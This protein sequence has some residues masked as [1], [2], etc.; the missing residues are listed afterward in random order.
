VI[1]PT[2][3]ARRGTAKADRRQYRGN[4]GRRAAES[5]HSAQKELPMKTTILHDEH[6]RILSISKVGELTAAG[7]K[8]MRV[9]MVPAA[10]QRLLELELSSEDEQ[11]S[12]SDLH[13]SY[14]VDVAGQKLVHKDF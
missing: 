4:H 7:S 3:A 14:R 6:G 11:R 8:F 10:G 2:A 5:K 13:R 9:G 12:L 1:W